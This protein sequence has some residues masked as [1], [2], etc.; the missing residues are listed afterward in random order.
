[1][2]LYIQYLCFDPE[3]KDLGP[4]TAGITWV[5]QSQRTQLSFYEHIHTFTKLATLLMLLK[6]GG[7]QCSLTLSMPKVLIFSS[8]DFTL[9]DLL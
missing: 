8:K 4:K 7:N 5:P 3:N 1:M 6:T 9:S 2:P